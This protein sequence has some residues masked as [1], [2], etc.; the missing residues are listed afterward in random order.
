[1]HSA[2]ILK[3]VLSLLILICQVLPWSLANYGSKDRAESAWLRMTNKQKSK[4]YNS[5]NSIGDETKIPD[6]FNPWNN[7][8]NIQSEQGIHNSPL[9]RS[10]DAAWHS[11]PFR[12]R[13]GSHEDQGLQKRDY[14]PEM[15]RFGPSHTKRAED[16]LVGL[17]SVPM[18]GKRSFEPQ[19]LCQ[20]C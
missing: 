14:R 4:I 5:Y 20:N 11:S 12:F 13:F 10:R 19:L 17:N 16:K 8:Q 15:F 1:M 3:S 6:W 18:L 2:F 7:M 9:K